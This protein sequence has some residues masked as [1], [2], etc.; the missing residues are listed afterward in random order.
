MFAMVIE[1][2]NPSLLYS[3]PHW[4]LPFWWIGTVLILSVFGFAGA[5]LLTWLKTHSAARAFQL[6]VKAL[7]E[8]LIEIVTLPAGCSRIFALAKLSFREA[9]RRRIL[10]VFFLFLIPFLFAGWYLPNSPEGQLRFLVAFV[11]GA[12]SWLLIPLSVFLVSMSLPTDIQQ[13]TIYTVVTKPV[14]RLE[15]LVGRILGFMGIFT[16]VLL[17]M[18]G[19][20]LI[21]LRGQSDATV[22]QSQ[23]TARVPI[24]A[25]AP[26]DVTTANELKLPLMFYKKGQLQAQGTNVGK[27][28]AYRSHIEGATSDSAHWFFQFDPSQFQNREEVPVELTFD[29]FKTTKGD[30]TRPG[31]EESGVWCLLRFVD[32]KTGETVFD[33]TFRVNNNRGNVVYVPAKAFASG[34]VEVI[35]QCLTRNQFLGMAP[36]DLYLL[37]DERTFEGNFLKGLVTIWLKIL[38]LTCVAVTASTFLKGFVTILFTFMV[39]ILGFFHD[40]MIGIVTGQVRGGGPL[41]SSIRLFTQNNQVTDL[42]PNFFNRIA[43]GVDMLLLELMR[44]L[45]YIIP[46]LT[47]LDTAEFV[48]SG[49]DIPWA[50]LLRN[51]L[52]VIGYVVP[53]VIFGYFV[54]KNRELAA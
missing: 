8:G 33:R 34:N 43:L 35:A 38:L 24:Y 10:Y 14:R 20:G 50:L 4:S 29:I 45:A 27:E 7:F 41:E 11:N 48:A 13:H 46:N 39:Y 28:W 17:I 15:I 30:P 44:A 12:I 25:T 5:L 42:D 49:F 32:R 1:T 51:A 54:F 40:F 9:I 26:E 21:Y 53:V 16:L 22:R 3:M 37:A 47:L 36:A 18:G 23:W 6:T 2:T 52:F 19:V 31:A